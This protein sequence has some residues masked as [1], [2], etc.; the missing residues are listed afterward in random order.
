MQAANAAEV[1]RIP[2]RGG[3]EM[4]L[5]GI[6]VKIELRPMPLVPDSYALVDYRGR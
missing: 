6:E 5:T 2:T 1:E 4:A 3:R